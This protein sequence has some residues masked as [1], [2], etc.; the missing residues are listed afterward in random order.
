VPDQLVAGRAGLL[1]LALLALALG[2]ALVAPSAGAKSPAGE[3]SLPAEDFARLDLAVLED[4]RSRSEGADAGPV[5]RPDGGPDRTTVF[6]VGVDEWGLTRSTASGSGPTA[7]LVPWPPEVARFRPRDGWA[8]VDRRAQL[9]VRFTAAMDHASTEAAFHASIGATEVTGSL[10]WAE[11]DTVLVLRPAAPLPYG[12][13]VELR[14]D[15]GALSAAG[16][17][18]AE[19]A[20]VSFTVEPRPAAPPDT[21]PASPGDWQWP[22]IGPLTQLFGQ[23]L[24][25]YGFHQGIDI[26]G[27]TGD[28]VRAA[29]AG[30]VVVAGHADECGGLQVRIDHGGGLLT[31]YRHLS[32]IE[33][34]TGAR[35]AVGTVIGRVGNTGCSL[36][37]HLHF[38]VS[39]NGEFVDP[40]RYLPAR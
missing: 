8:D 21:A 19:A 25:A 13:R 22:L 36:G 9:S 2:D 5:T 29:R 38:G 7:T 12:A 28:P 34:A 1:V 37:S 32:A 39:L 6:A 33:T 27:D 17:P 16:Q 11:G 23:T 31:W 3:G 26:D 20:A 10:R 14:V 30:V 15:A 24:T 35:V 40:I 18:V 4:L